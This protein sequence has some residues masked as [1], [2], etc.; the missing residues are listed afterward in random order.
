MTRQGLIEEFDFVVLNC[1]Y[2]I[3]T[4]VIKHFI[5]GVEEC[6]KYIGFCS[7]GVSCQ[8]MENGELRSGFQM[9]SEMTGVLVSKINPLS[10]AH[11]I[12]KKDD[13]LLAFDGVPIANDGTGIFSFISISLS[14]DFVPYF[15]G[16]VCFDVLQF[17]F[18]TGRESLSTIWFL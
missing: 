18:G 11:K 5:N 4:P 10:D 12:L 13:V 6:G 14:A 16:E 8:P 2:I 17:L 1:S 3:P 9:S 7:M 15:V